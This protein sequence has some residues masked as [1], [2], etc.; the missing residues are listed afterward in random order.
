M[1]IKDYEFYV[2]DEIITTEGVKGEVI[3]ICTCDKCQERGFYE[4]IWI[5]EHNKTE[6]YIDKFMAKAKFVGFYKIGK[7]RFDDFDKGE[8]LRNIAYHEDQLK[9]LKRQWSVIEEIENNT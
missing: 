9:I 6:R 5:D 1:N 4:P 8:V 7:Y 2:G 3:G